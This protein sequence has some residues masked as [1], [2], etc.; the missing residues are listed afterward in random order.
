MK[1]AMMTDLH[2]AVK[3]VLLM[4]VLT[5]LSVIMFFN[6]LQAIGA[7]EGGFHHGEFYDSRYGHN[8]YYPAHGHYVT[9]LPVDHR[10]FFHGGATYYFHGGV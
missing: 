1:N 8:Q 3:G 10:V 9:A 2:D 5:F 6:L 4:V 7:E